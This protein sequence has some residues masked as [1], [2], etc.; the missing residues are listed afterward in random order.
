MIISSSKTSRVY[1][2]VFELSALVWDHIRNPITIQKALTLLTKQEQHNKGRKRQGDD[3]GKRK[4]ESIGT[5]MKQ[6]K[7]WCRHGVV[8]IVTPEMRPF[9]RHR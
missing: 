3:D 4:Y 7:I 1:Q 8:V 2:K 5:A 6:I 9:T